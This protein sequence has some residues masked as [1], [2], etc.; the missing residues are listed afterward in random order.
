[1]KFLV[2]YRT[3]QRARRQLA[4][5]T[6]QQRDAGTRAWALWFGLADEFVVD[7]GSPIIDSRGSIGGFSIL[8]GESIQEVKKLLT[9]HPHNQIG[10]IEVLPFLSE[11]LGD[12][13]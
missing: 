12:E 10:T 4:Q 1:M 6:P 13:P 2:L 9:T 11:C 3:E 7:R 5:E 8:Q